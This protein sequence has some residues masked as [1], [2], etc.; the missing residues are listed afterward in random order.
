MVWGGGED[1][2][3]GLGEMQ[4]GGLVFAVAFDLR[5]QGFGWVGGEEGVHAGE[6]LVEAEVE[7]CLAVDHFED[8]VSEAAAEV[9][10]ADASVELGG[11]VEGLGCDERPG[12][13]VSSAVVSARDRNGGHEGGRWQMGHPG[14]AS[15]LCCLV[16]ARCTSFWSA[17]VVTSYSRLLAAFEDYVIIVAV[18]IC[19]QRL[20][21]AHCSWWWRKKTRLWCVVLEPQ[22]M[23]LY[24]ASIAIHIYKS[25]D[26]NTEWNNCIQWQEDVH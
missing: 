7:D 3:D 23:F 17:I 12:V 19:Q 13:G 6:D 26:R 4:G 8:V 15:Y 22:N 2:R 25:T 10:V 14:G 24:S 16:G 9:E 21:L 18:V 11:D 1:L 5:D 20:F